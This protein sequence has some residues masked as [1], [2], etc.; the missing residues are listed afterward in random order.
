MSKRVERP[1]S[2]RAIWAA[3]WAVVSMVARDRCDASGLRSV[4]G[5]ACCVGMSC[6]ATACATSDAA[7]GAEAGEPAASGEAVAGAGAGDASV[8]VGFRTFDASVTAGLSVV[9]TA[10]GETDAWSP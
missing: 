2:L 9:S 7:T 3:R 5:A 1:S 6:G 8:P 4:D 10:T